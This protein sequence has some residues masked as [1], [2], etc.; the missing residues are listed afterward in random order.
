MTESSS[1]DYGLSS[2][3]KKLIKVLY[4]WRNP[5]PSI[6]IRHVANDDALF[7]DIPGDTLEI[8]CYMDGFRLVQY[9]GEIK[10]EFCLM[11]CYGSRSYMSWKS[12]SEYREYYR[13]IHH[14][15][16][17][18]KPLFTQTIKDWADLQTR[19]KWFRCLSP[20]YL[21]EKCIYLGRFVQSSLL[22]CPTP[23]LLLEFVQHDS[24]NED[25]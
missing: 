21:V 24:S 6:S 19:K 25:E 8:S 18:I 4:Q 9:T 14:I 17:Q 23:G 16:T 7:S 3:K 22:E 10:A 1:D 11:F 15:H 2:H 12:Y 5:S 20:H 13:A